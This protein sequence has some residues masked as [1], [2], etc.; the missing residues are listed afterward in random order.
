METLIH[1]RGSFLSGVR[2]Q[3]ANMTDKKPL[4]PALP[5]DL[6]KRLEAIN[7]LTLPVRK[8]LEAFSPAVLQRI[9]ISDEITRPFREAEEEANRVIEILDKDPIEFLN[10]PNINPLVVLLILERNGNKKAEEVLNIKRAD[11][12]R[13]MILAA[14]NQYKAEH[15]TYPEWD[16]FW[17]YLSAN[18]PVGFDVSIEKGERGIREAVIKMG[19][20]ESIPKSNL[21]KRFERIMENDR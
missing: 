20:F 11:E 13:T 6:E 16:V 1:W 4:K 2:L 8:A 5:P 7:K 9:Q 17:V 14:I 12:W 19:K 18:P 10:L 21:K 15:G 3:G